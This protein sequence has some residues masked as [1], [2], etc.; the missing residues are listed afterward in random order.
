MRIS[1]ALGSII[2]NLSEVGGS[3]SLWEL[4]QDWPEWRLW[5]HFAQ[6]RSRVA[7]ENREDSGQHQAVLV[8]EWHREEFTATFTVRDQTM[9]SP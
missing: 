2:F 1:V 6:F 9:I 5:G 8:A 7:A 4:A 3:A